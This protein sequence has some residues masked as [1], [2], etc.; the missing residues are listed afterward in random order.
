MQNISQ[1]RSNGVATSASVSAGP[2]AAA[3]PPPTSATPAGSATRSSLKRELLAVMTAWPARDQGGAFKLW[4]RH[5]LSLV[6]LNVLSL[7]QAEGALSMRRLAE[8]MDVSDAS[9]TG[10]VDRMERRGLVER[11]RDQD[12]RRVVLVRQTDAGGRVFDDMAAHRRDTLSA[13]LDELSDD[14]MAALL[15]GMQA[16]QTARRRVMAAREARRDGSIRPPA[17]ASGRAP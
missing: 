15:K 2:Q 17:D 7:L 3:P 16:M 12:D 4:H 10:I 9:A 8:S 14:E 5:D 1:T 13:V 11:R 6:H